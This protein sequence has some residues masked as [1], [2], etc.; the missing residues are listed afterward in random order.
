MD[1]IPEGRGRE[2]L[3]NGCI[4]EAERFFLESRPGALYNHILNL[5]ERPLI[6]LVLARTE[7]NQ[8]K[9]AELLGINRNTLYSKIKKL[10]IDVE[11][12]KRS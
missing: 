9:A 4:G 12:F 5:V 8:K 10:N 2:Q 1:N 7:G 11:R 3:L 6:E